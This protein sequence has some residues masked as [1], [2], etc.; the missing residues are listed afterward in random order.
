MSFRLILTQELESSAEQNQGLLR[1]KN[2][3]AS[4]PE[5][6]KQDTNIHE[7]P[8]T[9]R[10]RRHSYAAQSMRQLGTHGTRCHH[11]YT[12]GGCPSRHKL[13]G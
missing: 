10:P 3:S 8:S 4:N 9:P 1:E 2:L 13:H 12:C 6:F 5:C 7:N 11:Q